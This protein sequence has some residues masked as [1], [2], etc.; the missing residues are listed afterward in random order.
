MSISELM[1]RSL[2]AAAIALGRPS[3]TS[4]FVVQHLPLQIVELEKIAI[5]DA[6]ESDAGP[7]ERFGDHRAQRAAA[8]D[9][10]AAVA[11]AAAARLRPAERIAPG[12][13]ND[14]SCCSAHRCSYRR[15][16]WRGSSQA[17][18]AMILGDDVV[19]LPRFHI[20]L[21]QVWQLGDHMHG[22]GTMALGHSSFCGPKI[23]KR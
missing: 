20:G 4:C 1:R 10:G 3:A 2:L 6:H 14:L 7:H 5:D 16:V 11:L 12:D 9:E 13:R 18:L 17:D 23:A 19:A 8:A 22:S 21:I 15:A